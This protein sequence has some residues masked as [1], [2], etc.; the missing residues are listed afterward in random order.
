MLQ[1]RSANFRPIYAVVF[2]L[3]VADFFLLAWTGT[4]PVDDYF[5]VIAAIVAIGYFVFF[6]FGGLFVGWLEKILAFRA[7]SK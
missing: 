3:F 5:K 2:W 7:F 4:T 1:L 6:V